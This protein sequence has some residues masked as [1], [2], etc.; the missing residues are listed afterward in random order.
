MEAVMSIILFL[1]SRVLL[2]H[3]VLV[4]CLFINF[5]F[6]ALIFFLCVVV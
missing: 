6:Q 1:S 5:V 2:V 3:L 4:V